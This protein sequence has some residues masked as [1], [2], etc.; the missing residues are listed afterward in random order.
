ETL[1]MADPNLTAIVL[2]QLHRLG[3]QIALDN[4]GA[5]PI[6]LC[7]LRTF[8]PDLIKTD[9]TLVLQMQAERVSRDVLALIAALAQKLPCEILAQG[10]ETVGQLQ[11]LRTL[12]C[13]FAQG[14]LLS[15]PLA[16]E[17]TTE[18]L[19]RHTCAADTPVR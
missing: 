11:H 9:R 7:A 8:A 5:G 16:P 14:Y 3:L 15:P 4:F 19:Q 1:A 6:S 17:A 2:P 18:F 10:V 12:G 13:H